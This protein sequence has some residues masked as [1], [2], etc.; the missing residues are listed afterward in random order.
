MYNTTFIKYFY[1]LVLFCIGF[2]AIYNDVTEPTGFKF[3]TGF[4]SLLVAIFIF[5]L[6][7]DSS[8]QLKALRIDIPET[9]FTRSDYINIPLFWVIVP[10]II[11]Q[12]IS[13]VFITITTDYVY[14]VYNRL[15]LNRDDR[16]RLNM[17]KW[18]FIISTLTVMLLI[19]SYCND[20]NMGQNSTNFAGSY[21]TLLLVAFIASIVLPISNLFISRKFSKLQFSITE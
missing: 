8:K 10:S 11:I 20:F 15:K 16:Y 18:M 14:R 3:I 1:L 9:V 13:S 12:L 7:N 21:K 19:Y 2:I 5:Q 6:L 17:Y 4:Q